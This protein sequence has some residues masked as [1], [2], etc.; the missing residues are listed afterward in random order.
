MDQVS[1]NEIERDI[2]P[3]DLYA[4]QKTDDPNP[5]AEIIRKRGDIAREVILELT[6]LLG[7]GGGRLWIPARKS[8]ERAARA[9]LMDRQ[10][11]E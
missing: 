5:I 8:M 2:Q 6:D 10:Y 11:S 7:E 3:A 1:L 4:L 9:R